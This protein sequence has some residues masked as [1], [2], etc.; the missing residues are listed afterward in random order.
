MM[1]VESSA[2]T[3]ARWFVGVLIMTYGFAKINGSQFTVP[4]SE[5]DRDLRTDVYFER[6][7]AYMAD[8]VDTAHSRAI[9]HFEVSDSTIR[10]WATWLRRDTLIMRGTI[11]R[12]TIHLQDTLGRALVLVGA[13]R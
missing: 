5:L 4:E 10:I 3:I 9:R 2:R 1:T 6:D 12:D 8:F 11:R 13:K 7:R